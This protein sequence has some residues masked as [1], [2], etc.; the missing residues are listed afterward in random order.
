MDLNNDF[1]RVTRFSEK[2]LKKIG[3]LSYTDLNEEQKKAYNEFVQTVTNNY[4][5]IGRNKPSFNNN[6]Y[7]VKDFIDKIYGT[8]IVD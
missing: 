2:T 3:L 4:C 1:N 8:I 6:N 5:I 7:Y